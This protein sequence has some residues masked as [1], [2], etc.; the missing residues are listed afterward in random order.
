MKQ[1][2]DD[3]SYDNVSAMDDRSNSNSGYNLRDDS[4]MTSHNMVTHTNQNQTRF[5]NYIA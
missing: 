5:Q 3:S 2:F 4:S 1:N